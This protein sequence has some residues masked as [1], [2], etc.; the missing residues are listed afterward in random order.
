V[1]L[2]K[3]T[4]TEADSATAAVLDHVP[5]PNRQARI[6]KAADT[7]AAVRF[8]PGFGSAIDV[9]VVS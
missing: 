1:H 2:T 6:S 3:M 7:P 4:P 5:L 9:E 8:S